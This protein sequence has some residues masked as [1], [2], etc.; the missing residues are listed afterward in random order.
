MRKRAPLTIVINDIPRRLPSRGLPRNSN[1]RPD[2][3]EQNLDSR[4]RAV[5]RVSATRA[6]RYRA[7]PGRGIRANGADNRQKE[8]ERGGEGEGENREYCNVL[9]WE[10]WSFDRALDYWQRA[11]YRYV[12]RVR[13]LAGVDDNPEAFCFPASLPRGRPRLNQVGAIRNDD[14]SSP[15]CLMQQARACRVIPC[16]IGL[17]A[18]ARSPPVKRD[19]DIYI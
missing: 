2:T 1:D 15:F 17:N 13:V 5:T 7:D 16:N 3:V 19:R 6:L 11:E 18:P 8:R 9:R 10:L 4:R 14:S 12:K